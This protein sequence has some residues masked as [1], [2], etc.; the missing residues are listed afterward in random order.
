MGFN[1]RFL[2]EELIKGYVK[3]HDFNEFDRMMTNS[4]FYTYLDTYSAQIGGEYVASD[5]E[6]KNKIYNQIKQCISN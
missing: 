3:T 4:D 6:N 2:S 1:K 5:K